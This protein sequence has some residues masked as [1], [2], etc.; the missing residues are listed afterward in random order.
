MGELIRYPLL[1]DSSSWKWSPSYNSHLKCKLY[2]PITTKNNIIQNPSI[3]WWLNLICMH[4]R[5]GTVPY[6][7]CLFPCSLLMALLTVSTVANYRTWCLHSFH[8]FCRLSY[9]LVNSYLFKSRFH[10]T[11]KSKH[12]FAALWLLMDLLLKLPQK[13]MTLSLQDVFEAGDRNH[14]Y[15]S[16]LSGCSLQQLLWCLCLKNDYADPN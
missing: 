14:N 12:S 4:N 16:E 2:N 10:I 7:F 6:G 1:P 8:V 13:T 9:S 3:A 11:S 15:L 5:Q